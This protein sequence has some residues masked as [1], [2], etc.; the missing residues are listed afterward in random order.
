MVLYS[1]RALLLV[2]DEETESSSSVGRE[3]T[4][5]ADGPR[6][7]LLN[8]LWTHGLGLFGFVG[9]LASSPDWRV[10]VVRWWWW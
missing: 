9:P 6:E 1:R 7:D 2:I 4:S 10:V 8:F 3:R 5:F